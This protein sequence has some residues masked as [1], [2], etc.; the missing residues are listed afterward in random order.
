MLH[1]CRVP[2]LP[3]LTV[4]KGSQLTRTC[5]LSD[6]GRYCALC[7]SAGYARRRRMNIYNSP[8]CLRNANENV[9][10]TRARA[11]NYRSVQPARKQFY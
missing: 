11:I 4:D 7:S 5:P 1:K 2:P 8:D 10:P 3:P 9:L 6:K